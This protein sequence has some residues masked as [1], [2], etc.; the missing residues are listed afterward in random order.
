MSEQIEIF[1]SFPT[2]DI[3]HGVSITVR[4]T[5]QILDLKLSSKVERAVNKLN[6][7]CVVDPIELWHV[8]K[9]NLKFDSPIQ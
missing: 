5:T 2:Q 7:D 1:I 9:V 4:L 6:D 3:L 8:W